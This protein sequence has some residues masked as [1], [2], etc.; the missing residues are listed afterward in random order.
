MP[1]AYVIQIGGRTAGIVARDGLD[2]RFNFFA[3]SHDFSALE[4]RSFPDPLTAERAGAP[5][6]EIWK[7]TAPSREPDDPIQAGGPACKRGCEPRKSVGE[8]PTI[9]LIVPASSAGEP[10]MDVH[11]CP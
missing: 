8:D 7:S 6:R 2:L 11:R 5:S 4:C 10:R 3:A 1:D 9:T